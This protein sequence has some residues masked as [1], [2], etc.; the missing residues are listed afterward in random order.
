MAVQAFNESDGALAA[1]V[2]VKDGPRPLEVVR[3]ASDT[4]VK[5]HALI[6]LASLST[7][8]RNNLDSTM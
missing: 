5:E 1:V 7:D 3:R 6:L 4:V 2:E 8:K